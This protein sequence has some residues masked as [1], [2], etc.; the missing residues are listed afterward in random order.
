MGYNMAA[1]PW[2]QAVNWRHE[3]HNMRQ[4]VSVLNLTERKK[5]LGKKISAW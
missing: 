5:G 1:E 2:T 3:K 4:L